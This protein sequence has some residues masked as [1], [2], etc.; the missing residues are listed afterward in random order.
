MC[1]KKTASPLLRALFLTVPLFLTWTV[2]LLYIAAL[3]GFGNSLLAHEANEFDAIKFD[4]ELAPLLRQYCYDCHANGEKSGNNALDELAATADQSPAVWYQVLKQLRSKSMPPSGEAAPTEVERFRAISWIKSDVFH[5]DANRPDP[6]MVT[7][8][9]LNRNEYRN[10]VRDL[11]GV[12]YDTKSNFPADDTGFG[13]DNIADVLTVSPLLLEKYL[14]AATE[15]IGKSVPIVSGIPPKTVVLGGDFVKEVA[16]DATAESSTNKPAIDDRS[17]NRDDERRSPSGSERL[18]MSYYEHAFAKS[19]TSI[20]TTGEYQVQINLTAAEKFVDNVFDYNRCRMIFKVDD[21]V[22]MDREFVRQGN[23]KLTLTFGLDLGVGDHTILIEVAPLTPDAPQ[24]R[25]LRLDVSN[26]ALIGPA[27]D[28]YLVPPP[29]YSRYFPK[30]VPKSDPKRR[31]YAKELLQQF[32]TKAFRRPVDDETVDRLVQVAESVYG[33]GKKTFENG[34]AQAMT[35]VLASPRFIFREEA[36]LPAVGETHPWLTDY[37]IASRLSYFLWSTMPDD[38]L[39][40]LAA[41]GDLRA[42]LDKQVER[43]LNDPRSSAFFQNFV[44]QWLQ[45][46]EIEEVTIDSRAVSG[47]ESAPD[48]AADRLRARFRELRSKAPEELTELEKAEIEEGIRSFSSRRNRGPNFDDRVRRAMRSETELLFQHILSKD[49]PLTDL[50]D[51]DY[52]FLNE[53]LASF[54]AIPELKPIEG[55]EMRLVNLPP[56][57]LRGGILTQGTF[58]AVTSNPNRTSPVKRGLFVLENVLGSPIA[59]P[60][61]NIPSLDDSAEKDGGTKRS[62]RETLAIHRENA[63][64]SS[65]HNK[66]DPIGLAFENF[67]AMGRWREREFGEAVDATGTLSSGEA[68]ADVREL[69]KVLVKNHQQEI[70]YCLAEKMMT[71]AL[72]RGLDYRD[73]YAL[74]EIVQRIEKS[75]GKAR[76]LLDGVVHSN[77]FLKRRQRTPGGD[78]PASQ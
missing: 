29:G 5:Q 1:I 75:G 23:E 21:K 55:D 6:G 3:C 51:S 63:V 15:I 38:E 17:R 46:R 73:D 27:G 53:P 61:P 18:T 70:H 65:C 66:M 39:M 4:A 47:R 76:A 48:P 33:N 49:L 74:D 67:N 22:L 7:V 9:R 42:N 16:K 19:T 20:S 25:A 69:K 14:A 72:G 13:F 78:S 35:A 37:A 64:C 56:N 68:F 11:L 50:I 77:Q 43:M 41:Q 28:E 57:S 34:V 36:V 2:R 58:L 59:A 26:V 30:L 45:S 12:E 62:L 10:T 8:R 31:E 52:A 32:A 71:Y 60:P 44:G 54:Y 40:Q 24:V